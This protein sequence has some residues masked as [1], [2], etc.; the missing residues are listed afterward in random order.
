MKRIHRWILVLL[1]SIIAI[2]PIIGTNGA[3]TIIST[4]I[5]IRDNEKAYRENIGVNIG[6]TLK[7]C[8]VVFKPG[9]TTNQNVTFRTSDPAVATAV[10]RKVNGMTYVDI[11]GH[12]EGVTTLIATAADSG[13]T[14]SCLVTV[15]TPI[16]EA[17]GELTE[18]MQLKQSALDSASSF[19]TTCLAGQRGR[20][21]GSVG[22]YYYFDCPAGV[23]EKN[24]HVAYVPKNKV[25][26]YANSVKLNKNS[27]TLN[28]GK[29]ERLTA[30]ISPSVTTNQTV[31]YK[32]SDTSVATVS[33]KG[34]V[35]AKKKG[36]AVITVTTKSRYK[37][38]DKTR[39]DTCHVTVSQPVT[40]LLMKPARITLNKGK[41]RKLKLQIR[42]SNA[43]DKEIQWTTS[44][45]SLAMVDSDGK[46]TAKAEGKATITAT[47]VASG[48]KATCKITIV[49]MDA[50]E[51]TGETEMEVGK[52][53]SVQAVKKGAVSKQAKKAVSQN[54]VYTSSNPKIAK[55]NKKTGEVTP[56]KSGK[57]TITARA[58]KTNKVVT[59]SFTSFILTKA[60][61][62]RLKNVRRF[63]IMAL[64]QTRCIVGDSLE[65]YKDLEF[66]TMSPAFSSVNIRG[67]VYAKGD[68]MFTIITQLK[69]K[70]VYTR[71]YSYRPM[72]SYGIIQDNTQLTYE[73]G[74]DK[75]TQPVKKNERVDIKGKV[76]KWF[77][78]VALL[79]K[80]NQVKRFGVVPQNCVLTYDKKEN[81]DYFAEKRKDD[82][83][84]LTYG[85]T[86]KQIVRTNSPIQVG[87]ANDTVHIY[88]NFKYYGKSANTRFTYTQK[89]GEIKYDETYKEVFE[90]GIKKYWGDMGKKIFEGG[91]HT[92][93]QKRFDTHTYM[94][95]TTTYTEQDFANGVNLKCKVHINERTTKNSKYIPVYIGG[96][97]GSDG[98]YWFW[99][100]STEQKIKK[101]VSGK[102]GYYDRY[103]T[104]NE[105]RCVV[106]PTNHEL[107]QNKTKKG[108]F[109]LDMYKRTCAH[110]FGHIL[111][112]N[113]AYELKVDNSYEKTTIKRIDSSFLSKY[114]KEVCIMQYERSTRLGSIKTNDLEMALYA[115]S[116]SQNKEK[117]YKSWQNYRQFQYR[118]NSG[119]LQVFP[120]SEAITWKERK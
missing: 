47:N 13:V 79:G 104:M 55:V 56:L 36:L 114:Y 2:Y 112:L 115:F 118:S 61:K 46:V 97:K 83:K 57:F 30:T 74:L 63:M 16:E 14:Y 71:V 70:K 27:L 81:R 101:Q 100:N 111:G 103:N 6:T 18:S 119:K 26:I 75:A 53:Y 25:T 23:L 15:R 24:Y 84:N 44:D 86:E 28:K 51:L 62:K 41:S 67:R 22:N 108:E 4:E 37:G 50:Y 31:T 7:T 42:P 45:T 87:I 120:R 8:Y 109:R 64:Y 106:I 33:A 12:A 78:Y 11:T 1:F 59:G 35:K 98:N 39:T 110:E 88:V 85:N 43:N 52:T 94:M 38:Q 116:N 20:I 32:S 49:D 65:D 58:K 48:K 68:T 99:V 77:Y 107:A 105:G 69:G 96:K 72:V 21:K 73:K 9:N 3:D 117:H 60:E 89:N 95:K 10:G 82:L 76:G 19:T 113:D 66:S 91:I 92:F 54:W 5:V 93:S 34:M 17:E 90:S 80:D 40:K 29:K 102:V